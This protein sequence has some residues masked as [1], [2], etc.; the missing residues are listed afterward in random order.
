MLTTRKYIHGCRNTFWLGQ[1]EV[2]TLY[3]E[4]A[5]L[6]SAITPKNVVC[7]KIKVEILFLSRERIM[8]DVFEK[9]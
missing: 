9:D 4:K 6:F 2:T 3:K 7:Q 8:R 5:L 1:I